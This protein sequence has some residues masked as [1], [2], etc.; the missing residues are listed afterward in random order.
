MALEHRQQKHISQIIFLDVDN[1]D[2]EA[3]VMRHRSSACMR[4]PYVASGFANGVCSH[5]D[6]CLATS[7]E[8][9]VCLSGGLGRGA[10]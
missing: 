2:T 3:H 10:L 8:V 1:I 5:S 4:F 9:L 6:R 7:S